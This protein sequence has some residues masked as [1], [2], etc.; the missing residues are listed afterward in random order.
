MTD[1]INTINIISSKVS[2]LAAAV[3]KINRKT[4]KLGC[5]KIKFIVGKSYI[6]RE[7]NWDTP[8]KSV[9]VKRTEISLIGQMPNIPDWE[10]SA[11][12]DHFPI[13]L[14]HSYQEIPEFYRNRGSFCD[15]CN[16]MRRRNKTII[17]KNKTT[18]EFKQVGSTCLKDFIDIDIT[19]E[20]SF[21]T[22]I[23]S[24]SDDYGYDP[25][26]VGNGKN[27]YLET[28]KDVFS[29]GIQ[30]IN[31]FGFVKSHDGDLEAGIIPTKMRID[32]YFENHD[33]IQEFYNNKFNLT[34][35][36]VESK[37]NKIFDW[38]N[39]NNSKNEFIL[40]LQA[41]I[42]TEYTEWKYYGYI[43]GAIASYNREMEKYIVK[44][45]EILNEYREESIK[46]RITIPVYLKTIRAIES[47]YGTSYMHKFMD[48]NNREII[49]FCS[50]NPLMDSSEINPDQKITI[51]GTIKDKKEYNGK[52]TTYLNRVTM[53]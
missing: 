13:T 8:P 52:K 12:I 18:N 6:S 30:M 23:D 44:K 27:I 43:A 48:E 20:L 17:L 41:I 19:H 3:A 5:E 15:H 35:A 33:N 26:Y 10:V 28:T 2:E 31:S 16:S 11:V 25:E 40:N 50:G 42:S 51:T 22:F 37:V 9:N 39:N 49:W 45:I 4:D 7:L 32:S 47:F 36:E 29:I 24:I 21:L 1:H 46:S 38:I 34:S 14:V 53:K